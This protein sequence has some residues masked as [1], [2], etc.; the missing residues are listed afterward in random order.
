MN[1]R[2]NLVRHAPVTGKKGIVYGDDAD[3]DM[4]GQSE[5]ILALSS[6]L[7]SPDKAD[8]YSSGVDRAY[9]SGK[10]VLDK[11][12]SDFELGYLLR[13]HS[14]FREQNFG[15]LIGKSHD[16]IRD[17]AQF[18]DGKLF[19]PAPP[20]GEMI[21]DFILRVAAAVRDV[22]KTAQKNKRNNIVIFCHG[23]TIRAAHV[24]I[25]MMD[26]NDFILLDTPPLSL[27]TYNVDKF[28]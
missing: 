26:H 4:R 16:E 27:H 19:A 13:K 18:V 1:I 2:L 3:I 23:G 5:A 24:A 25:K 20:A 11:M 9:R 7:P 21:G 17:S 14:G 15:E 8:W 10:A 6:Q 22:K 28:Q 12:N